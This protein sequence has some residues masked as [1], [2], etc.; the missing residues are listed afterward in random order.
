VRLGEWAERWF[1]TTAALRPSTRRDY[2]NLLDHQVLPT[3]AEARLTE[4]DALAVR[5][6]LAELTAGGLGAK[7]APRPTPF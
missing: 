7:R 4:L 3:F 5:E 1:A 6:W 2:R